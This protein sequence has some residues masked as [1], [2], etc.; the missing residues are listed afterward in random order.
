MKLDKKIHEGILLKRYKRFFADV[1]FNG[2]VL[3]VHVPNTGSLKGV[4][5]KNQKQKCWFSLH[6]DESKKLKGS[7][8][9]VQV[10]KIWV[11]INT[12]YP[13]KIIKEAALAGIASGKPHFKHWKGYGYYRSE[14][15]ISDETRLDG[16][17]CASEADLERAKTPK[18]F[19]EIKNTTLL[20]E[21]DGQR[22]AQ[23]PDAVTER[24]QKHIKELMKL[25]KQ[26]HK[27]ELIFTVQRE[28]VERFAPAEDIDP[29]YAKLLRQAIKAGL[30]VTPVV[31][32]VSKSEIK[33]TQKV[34]VF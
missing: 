2:D 18:H 5:D 20:K 17:F 30:I 26:G 27:A 32:S 25:M 6:G 3:T 21:V 34:L 1:E 10:G 12:S 4:I 24:G 31:V 19:I 13:N 14:Y 9:A 7:L 16:L 15:K 28:D 23:F 33:L 22:V 29:E 8:E 11:G